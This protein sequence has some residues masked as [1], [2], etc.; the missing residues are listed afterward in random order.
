MNHNQAWSRR[1]RNQHRGSRDAIDTHGPNVLY[2]P[3]RL[4]SSHHRLHFPHTGDPTLAIGRVTGGEGMAGALLCSGI[5]SARER[6][7][8]AVALPA[9]GP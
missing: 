6:L 9:L 4:K 5:G 1:L 2:V 7:L 8:T 3:F